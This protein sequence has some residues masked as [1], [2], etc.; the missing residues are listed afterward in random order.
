V[1]LRRTARK[2]AWIAKRRV[3]ARIDQK[4]QLRACGRLFSAAAG[5]GH[6]VWNRSAKPFVATWHWLCNYARRR[7]SPIAST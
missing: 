2:D 6:P 5:H 7:S 1:R 3:R 4:C